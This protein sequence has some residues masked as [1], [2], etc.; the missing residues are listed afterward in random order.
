MRTATRFPLER[1]VAIDRAIRAGYFPNATSLGRELEV[2]PRTIH[3]DI[4]FARDRL[5]APIVFDARRNGYTYSDPGYR[6]SSISITE[7]EL[8]AL[9]VAERA[10]RQYQGSPFSA[11]L[12]RAFAKIQA[13]L[14]DRI[15]VEFGRLGESY[16]LHTTAPASCEPGLFGDMAK[17]VIGKRRLII[18][19]ASISRKEPAR[20]EVDPYHLAGVDGQWYLVAYCHLRREVR[21]FVPSRIVDL[22]LTEQ[23]FEVPADFRI[24]NYLGKSFSVFRGES[25]ET[26][27]IRIRFRGVAARLV[28]ERT[29]HPTQTIE[30]TAEGDLIVGLTLSHLREVERWVLSWGADAE[31]LEPIELRESVRDSLLNTSVQYTDLL[32]HPVTAKDVLRSCSDHPAR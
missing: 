29:W 3:R 2:D 32:T 20:R 31:V 25:G 17:A 13:G 5:N 14:T 30:R 10:L 16:S 6:F 23:R 4:E 21:L 19:Y 12:E 15:S 1:L 18:E 8:V 28:A 7:G 9:F 11:D 27:E 24:E 22:E 26:H